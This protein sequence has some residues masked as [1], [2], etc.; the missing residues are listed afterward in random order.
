MSEVVDPYV[1]P[2]TGILK[3]L[4]GARTQAEL[5][6]IEA[7]LVPIREVRLRARLPKPT[8]DLTELRAIHRTLFEAIYGWAGEL[9][10]VDIRKNIE[11]GEYFVPVS[12]VSF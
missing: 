8:R 11:G 4:V 10:T 7:D 2:A 1:D 5:D 6:A 3:N 12:P 9:R